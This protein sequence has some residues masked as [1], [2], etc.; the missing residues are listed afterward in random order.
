[1]LTIPYFLLR[2]K[3][4]LFVISELSKCSSYTPT[5]YHIVV[6]LN[7]PIQLGNETLYFRLRLW[8]HPLNPQLTDYEPLAI[9][10]LTIPS[11]A[12]LGTYRT[13]CPKLQAHTTKSSEPKLQSI[14]GYQSST[15]LSPYIIGK[16]SHNA[17]TTSSQAVG[18]N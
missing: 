6:S 10:Q 1:M 12:F 14:P 13:K 9:F 7:I 8:K 5:T 18:P 16:I 15:T 4:V 11:L 17:S 2:L 3:K